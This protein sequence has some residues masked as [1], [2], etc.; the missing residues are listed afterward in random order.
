VLILQ[1]GR[2]DPSIE[3]NLSLVGFGYGGA[4]FTALPQ[5][6]PQLNPASPAIAHRPSLSNLRL[7]IALYFNSLFSLLFAV[8]IGACSVQKVL[9]FNKR[10]SISVVVVWIC[11]EP[12]RIFYGMSG[13]LKERVPELSTYILVTIFPQMPFIIYLAYVQPV[14]FPADP[15]LGSFMLVFLCV[16]VVF[17]L[18]TVRMLIRSQTARFLRVCE[19]DRDR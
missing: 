10:V 1:F 2:V 17:G 3:G 18:Q 15:I 5:S 8:V 12:I 11:F 7:Q 4:M 6:D 13:N 16:Q 19:E 9:Y 14:L